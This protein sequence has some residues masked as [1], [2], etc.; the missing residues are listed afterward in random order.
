MHALLSIVLALIGLAFQPTPAA[1]HEP[2]ELVAQTCDD[3]LDF[4]L[5]LADPDVQTQIVYVEDLGDVTLVAA[6]HTVGGEGG[7][8]LVWA[9]MYTFPS[10]I[11]AHS[12]VTVPFHADEMD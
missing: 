5:L 3:C 1:S 9:A 10:T 11:Y 4:F 2:L 7:E 8:E 12:I 6:V